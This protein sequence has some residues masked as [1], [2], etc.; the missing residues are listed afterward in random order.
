[1]DTNDIN[2]F[3]NSP[4]IKTSASTQSFKTKINKEKNLKL[5]KSAFSDHKFDR[6]LEA[7]NELSTKLTMEISEPTKAVSGMTR[8]LKEVKQSNFETLCQFFH[9]FFGKVKI[10]IKLDHPINRIKPATTE[11]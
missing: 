6:F 5:T 7:K 4:K 1:M 3:E 9:N 11:P 8:N 2:G 10:R